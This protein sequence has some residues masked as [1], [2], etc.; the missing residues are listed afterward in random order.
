MYCFLWGTNW[1]YV[2]YVEESRPALWSSGQSSWLQIQRS[3]FCSRRYHIFWEAVCL[4]RGPFSEVSTNEE[5]FEINGFRLE[6]QEYGRRNPSFWPRDT[7]LSAKVGTNF[8]DNRLSLGRYSSIADSGHGVF[9]VVL[10]VREIMAWNRKLEF[11]EMEASSRNY[12]LF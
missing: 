4:E 12:V 1:I 6:N 5:L 11:P 7:P 8:A 2:C 9:Y 10:S 3:G